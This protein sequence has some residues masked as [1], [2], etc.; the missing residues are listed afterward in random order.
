M[1]NCRRQFVMLL[2]TTLFLP[3]VSQS[4]LHAAKRKKVYMTYIL[5]GNMN[6]DRYERPTIW[7][8]FPVIYNNLLDFMD[9]HP[10][11]K[12]QVQFSGQT[13]GSLLQAA[14]QVVEHAKAIHR[15]G[16]LNFTGTF[17][18]EP[19]NVNM[20]G[21]TNYRCAWLGTRIVEH[22]T[23][24]KTDGF[25][26]QERAYHPQLPGILSRAGV[27]WIPVIT[28]DSSW[29]PFRLRGLD[30]NCSVCVPITRDDFIAK[31][32]EAPD[33]SLITIEEDYEFPQT[34]VGAYNRAKEFNASQRDTEIIWITAAE[35]IRKF[36]IDEERYIDHAAKARNRDNGTYSRWTADP[37]DIQIQALTNE[38][39]SW[40]HLAK[41]TVGLA[42]H[43]AGISLDED[44]TASGFRLRWEPLAWN[45]ERADLY[46]DVEPLFLKREGRIT[47]LTK[48]EHLLLWAVNSDSKGWYP[49]YEKRRERMN[50]L[51]NCT[52]ICRFV[53]NRG[54]DKLA[55]Q[56]ALPDA[57]ADRWYVLL[58][59]EAARKQTI[60]IQSPYPLSFFDIATKAKLPSVAHQEG[61][62]YRMQVEACMPAFGY[63]LI[64]ARRLA[65]ATGKVWHDSRSISC[66]ETTLAAEGGCV[67]MQALGHRVEL[68][69]DDFQVK[70]LA[71]MSAGEGDGEWRPAKPDSAQRVTVSDDGLYPQLR[72]ERQLD[73]LV[74]L[75]QTFTLEPDR[76]LIDLHFEFP[77]P[78]LVR[79]DG[80]SPKFTFSPEGLT[81]LVN[82]HRRG[83]VGYD[84]P[85]GVSEYA[86]EGISYFC[87]L[88]SLWMQHD[89]GGLLVS[90][91][92]GEQAFCADLDKG[93]IKLYLGASTTSGPIR[94]ATLEFLDRTNVLQHECWYAEPFHGAYNHRV[95]L[96]PFK[97][98]WSEAHIPQT[99][100][101][102]SQPV[103]IREVIL[104]NGKGRIPAEATLMQV[105]QPNVDVTTIDDEGN[106][107]MLRLNEREGLATNALVTVGQQQ[108]HAELPPFGVVQIRLR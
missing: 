70:A 28:G 30:G 73:R 13:F 99:L 83:T 56:L 78:T 46:P 63:K 60:D 20:D 94:P 81:L 64:G 6:Y 72:I 88:S 75:Q 87:P 96:V 2:L 65:E 91:Q 9:E 106:G 27:S 82:T 93:C 84:I 44:F 31:A 36:G 97:G 76:V 53:V 107:M 43:L 85:Y 103:C 58:N 77:H 74:H 29:K 25:Y 14:P 54:L 4:A 79:K 8:H 68:A 34:F 61:S 89:D 67:V 23:G 15:R 18:S 7:E 71:E 98:R 52:D 101:A 38:A 24:E 104:G 35:Y 92:T 102:I 57:D 105:G 3:C 59:M 33:G 39:M 12:G 69:L 11:F 32:K 22:I 86:Q 16:Q 95:A 45:I 5:H 37:L 50:A 51:Q 41:M 1:R 19:V 62:G 10:D 49:L 17:Y 26:L 90:P 47:L 80:A 66:G 40:M 100:R 42:R 55:A 48:A 21:E 108:Y